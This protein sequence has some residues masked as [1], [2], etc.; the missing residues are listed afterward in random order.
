M[1]AAALQLE[2][3]DTS[4]LIKHIKELEEHF[5]RQIRELTTESFS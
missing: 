2:T 5:G 4:S 1:Q 3:L